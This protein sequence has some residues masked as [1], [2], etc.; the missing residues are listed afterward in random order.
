VTDQK[1]T[2][3]NDNNRLGMPD[4]LGYIEVVSPIGIALIEK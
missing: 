4:P 2:R 3:Y 1:F